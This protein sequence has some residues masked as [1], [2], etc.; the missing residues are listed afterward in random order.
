MESRNNKKC[1]ICNKR[2]SRGGSP[3][4]LSR[5]P[6]DSDRCRMWVKNAGLED[7]AYVPIEKLH[8]LKFVCGGHFTPESFNA[9]GTRL[10]N[11]AIPTLELSNPILPDEVLTEFPLHVKDS[12]KENLKTV[13]YDHSYCIPKK[14]NPVE[15]VPLTT[16]TKQLNS[17]CLG[18][19]DIP[20]SGISAK[21]TFEPLPS[22][23]N[24]PEHMTYK[25]ITHDDKNICH[26]DAQAE[27]LVHSY[28][29]PKKNIEMKDTS[30]T[31]TIKEKRLWRQLQNA[32]KTIRNIAKVVAEEHNRNFLNIKK[33][34]ST[35]VNPTF[36]TKMRVK[37]A[38]HALSNTV[39]AILKMM[40]WK[41]VSDCNDTAFVIEQLDKLFDCTNG[42]SSL[43][44][45]KKGIRENV[46]TS[47]NHIESWTFYTDKLKSLKFITAENTILKNVKCV[48]GYQISIKSLNDIWEKLKNEGFKYMNLRQFNQ[49]SLENLFGIIRQHSVTNRNPTI[50]HFTAALKTSMVTGLKVPHSRSANC[51]AD[52]NKHMLEYKDILKTNLK[53]T[54]IKINVQDSTDTEFYP[55]LSIPDP[56]NLEQPIENLCS[57][58]NQPVVYVS[59]YLAAKLLQNSSCLICEECLSVK[60]PVDNDLYAYISLREWWHDKKSLVYPTIQLCTTVNEAKQ[61][62]HD[63]IADQI[64]MEN[65]GK[66][67]FLMLSTNC[68]FSWFKCQQHNK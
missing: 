30:S 38:A 26:Q 21:T 36:K 29:R 8:Q 12:N 16:T 35:I 43:N 57:L 31:F 66:F 33:L 40:A 68:N 39:A 54:E 48:K 58:E 25:P 53:T 32:K 37:Y 15:R 7:L 17:T 49:D 47:S 46:S 56:E 6:L 62:Y 51:E 42:P 18:A 60:T 61:F 1:V 45:V 2:R 64:Y 19:V 24:A 34:N 9:K 20:D 13:L 14:S 41:E 59:G 22:T 23:S 5:F 4:L 28:K 11:S 27:I 50:T 63:H 3:L 65:V 52:N 67:I 10:K 44:D 55:V